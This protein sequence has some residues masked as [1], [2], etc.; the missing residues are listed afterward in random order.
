MA[1]HRPDDDH[2]QTE[3]PAAH[4]QDDL[5]D[6]LACPL[7]SEES[8]CPCGARAEAGRLCPKCRARA[9]WAQRRAHRDRADPE[10]GPRRLRRS[11]A[12]G[13]ESRRPESDCPR[14]RRPRGRRPER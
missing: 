7:Y 6:G 5:A 3:D 2:S 4:G 1:C 14:Q 9:A 10:H 13:A 8:R 12:R 11:G